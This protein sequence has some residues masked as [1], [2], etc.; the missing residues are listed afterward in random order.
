MQKVVFFR[1]AK[2][3]G[4]SSPYFNNAIVEQSPVHD[5]LDMNLD[6]KLLF[7]EYINGKNMKL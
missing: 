7:T 5:Y 1:E 3:V 2:K 6:S 4:K